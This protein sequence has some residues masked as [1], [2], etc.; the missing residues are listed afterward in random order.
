MKNV[1]NEKKI[2]A[3]AKALRDNLKRRKEQISQRKKTN[4]ITNN[5]DEIK[6]K[7]EE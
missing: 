6:S 5:I 3:R 7:K 2:D 4:N 1:K